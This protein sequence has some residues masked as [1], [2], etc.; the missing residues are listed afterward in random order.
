[1][2]G[3]RRDLKDFSA[4]LS[5]AIEEYAMKHYPQ[6]LADGLNKANDHEIN[7]QIKETLSRELS[8]VKTSRAAQK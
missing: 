8:K 4:V 7:K 2:V 3:T 6:L 1:M 5:A